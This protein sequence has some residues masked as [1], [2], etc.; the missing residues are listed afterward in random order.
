[1]TKK[2][3]LAKFKESIKVAE[4]PYKKDEYIEINEA[5]QLVSG[6]QGIPQGHCVQIYG[7]SNGG[8]TTIALHM[9]SQAQKQDIIPVFVITE[10]K[11]SLDRAAAMGVDME[12]AIMVNA[13]YI[14][15]IFSEIGKLLALQASGDLPKD[16]LFIVD[17]IGNTISRDSVKVAKDGTMETGGAMMLAA[18]RIRENMRIYSHKINDTRKINSPHFSSMVFINHSYTKPPAFPGAMSTDVP[19]GGD[20]IY[21]ASS[22]VIK[23]KK[24]KQLK[25]VKDG[26]DVSF[27]IVSK[28]AVEKNHI[29]GISNSGEFVITADS[30]IPNDPEAI[31]A[32]KSENSDSWGKF[33]IEE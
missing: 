28:I 29:N 18:K 32:Y 19:Y 21:Y 2:F 3:D 22:L 9:A 24:A 13:T 30:I 20:G 23:V 10:D 27:A 8:K 25:A 31:K 12:Q 4:V 7:P 11:L 33:E 5:L 15:D 17:S 16:L 26:Q 1:M 14:E 6:L